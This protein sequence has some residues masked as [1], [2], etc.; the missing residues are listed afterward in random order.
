MS[1]NSRANGFDR[2][3][4]EP[5]TCPESPTGRHE[6]VPC[7]WC[8]APPEWTEPVAAT[9][10]LFK[11]VNGQRIGRE[12]RVMAKDEPEAMRLALGAAA[13]YTAERVTWG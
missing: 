8:G 3:E 2:V 1:S 12:V 11:V 13:G 7:Q 4:G 6:H 9:V 5:V 10:H